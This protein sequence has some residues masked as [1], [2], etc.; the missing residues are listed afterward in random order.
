MMECFGT[1]CGNSDVTD[2]NP[3][4]Y[5]FAMVPPLRAPDFETID[6]ST[7]TDNNAYKI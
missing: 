7:Q 3:N 5:E 1:F 6:K 2:N 4:N